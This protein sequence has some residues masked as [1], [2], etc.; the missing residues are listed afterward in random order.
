MARFVRGQR[1][2]PRIRQPLHESV[3]DYPSIDLVD[4]FFFS[5]F[6][7]AANHAIQKLLLLLFFLDTCW[8]LRLWERLHLFYSSFSHGGS[9]YPPEVEELFPKI[10]KRPFQLWHLANL[11]QLRRKSTMATMTSELRSLINF[12]SSNDVKLISNY[13]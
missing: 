6:P 2:L 3:R 8:L 1:R 5:S 9:T 12:S 10:D 7:T 4:F 13:N 11:P